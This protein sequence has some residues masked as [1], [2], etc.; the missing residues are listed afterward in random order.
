MR[1]SAAALVCDAAR[2]WRGQLAWRAAAPLCSASN[3]N[4]ANLARPPWIARAKICSVIA[5]SY[6]FLRLPTPPPPT[7]CAFIPLNPA[8]PEPNRSKQG[9]RPGSQ[10]PNVESGKSSSPLRRDSWAEQH[11]RR[12]HAERVHADRPTA[13]AETR[14]VRGP[15][16]RPLGRNFCPSRRQPPCAAPVAPAPG[17]LT[18]CPRCSTAITKTLSEYCHAGIAWLST[19]RYQS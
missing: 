13:G 9:G 16:R 15:S 10:Q 7:F 18:P 4:I 8:K 19:A 5:A 17:I 6:A 3:M 2:C 12:D 1:C 11:L 14:R